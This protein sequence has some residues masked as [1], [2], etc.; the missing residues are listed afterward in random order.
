MSMNPF[1]VLTWTC[2]YDGLETTEPE[3]HLQVHGLTIETVVEHLEALEAARKD[4][5]R[6][7]MMDQELLEVCPMCGREYE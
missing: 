4:L 7:L 2:P 6:L 3:K 1:E 5:A